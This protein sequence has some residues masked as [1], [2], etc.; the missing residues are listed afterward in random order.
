MRKTRIG[1]MVLGVIWFLAIPLQAREVPLQSKDAKPLSKESFEESVRLLGKSGQYINYPAISSRKYPSSFGFVQTLSSP[2]VR[3]VLDEIGNFKRSDKPL[4][5]CEAVFK[6]TFTEY[7]Q[8]AD[9]VLK[10]YEVPGT[11][12]NKKSLYPRT[13]AVCAGILCFAELGHTDAVLKKLETVDAFIDKTK[14]RITANAKTFPEH[15]E[16]FT[17][18]FLRP[19]NIYRFNVLLYS[20]SQNNKAQCEKIVKELKT[21]VGTW[22]DIAEWHEFPRPLRHPANQNL[23]EP[24]KMVM[25]YDWP[26]SVGYDPEKQKA[27]LERLKG[28]LKPAGKPK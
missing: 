18:C 28:L 2:R 12:S 14:E 25:A 13:Q 9:A 4:A 7:K 26:E 5:K 10:H 20:C 21:P 24:V 11:P 16:D 1:A 15:F 23:A 22:V 19:S 6:Q 8:A 3:K 27:L 17:E